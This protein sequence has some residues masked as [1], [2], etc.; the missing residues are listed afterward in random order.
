MVFRKKPNFNLKLKF[1]KKTGHNS[2][3]KSVDTSLFECY[4]SVTFDLNNLKSM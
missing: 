2:R 4:D 3:G 1:A